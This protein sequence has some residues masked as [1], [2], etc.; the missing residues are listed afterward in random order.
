MK[1]TSDGKR[2]EIYKF[3][4]KLRIDALTINCYSTIKKLK[5]LVTV[6]A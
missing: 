2:K 1:V 5:G 6:L 4:F 3:G